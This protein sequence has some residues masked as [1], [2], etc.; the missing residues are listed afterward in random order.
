MEELWEDFWE[1]GSVTDYLKYKKAA[2][3]IMA[4][5]NRMIFGEKMQRPKSVNCEAAMAWPDIR[6]VENE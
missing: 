6:D 4:D 2:R 1:S 3:L 5:R